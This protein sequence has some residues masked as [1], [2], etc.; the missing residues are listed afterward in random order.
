MTSA[1]SFQALQKRQ[2]VA[3]FFGGTRI[4]Q[5]FGHE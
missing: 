5:A 1:G 3:H 2:Q 4:E